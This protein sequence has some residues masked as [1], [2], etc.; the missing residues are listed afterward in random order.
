MTTAKN[1]TIDQTGSPIGRPARAARDADGSGPQ[2]DRPRSQRGGHAGGAR[3]DRARSRT[4]CASSTAIEDATMKLNEIRD[5]PGAHEVAQARR[6]RHRLG[7]GQDGGPRRQGPD[8]AHRRAHQGLRGRPDAAASP[9]AEARLQPAVAARSQRGQS[10]PPAERDRRRQAR[11]RQ[12]DRRSRRW[13]PPAWSRRARDG[14]KLLG[15][16]ELKAKLSFEV[17]GASKSAVEAV[18][19]AG[20]SVKTLKADAVAVS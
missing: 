4:W 11:R 9:P 17:S 10:R 3:H 6:P 2:Q 13:S 1:V 14:V 19:K 18:E 20:G 5:N 7:Q 12:A 8:G 16:G 15:K